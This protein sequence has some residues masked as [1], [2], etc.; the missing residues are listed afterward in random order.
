MKKEE[1]E[2]IHQNEIKNIK[3]EEL[4]IQSLENFYSAFSTASRI[5]ILYLLSMSS[6]CVC[7]LASLLNMTKSAVSHQL[8]YLKE[9]GLIK[10]E[11][12]GKE[13]QYSLLDKHVKDLIDISIEHIGEGTYDKGI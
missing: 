9:L 12:N 4:L 3:I 13:V 7:E 8:K 5:K 11:K 2:H 1:C 6:F 10:G